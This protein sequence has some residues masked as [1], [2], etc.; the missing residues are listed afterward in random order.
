M[1]GLSAS[2]RRTGIDPD[3]ISATALSISAAPSPRPGE[4]PIPMTYQNNVHPT[5][6]VHD[7]TGHDAGDQYTESGMRVPAAEVRARAVA[8]QAGRWLSFA[9]ERTRMQPRTLTAKALQSTAFSVQRRASSFAIPSKLTGTSKHQRALWR[10]VSDPA[11]P[12]AALDLG[13]TSDGLTASHD[14]EPLGLVQTKHLGWVQPLV[15][16]G[17][18]LHLARVTGHD[19]EAYTLGANVAFGHVGQALDRL[20]VALSQA[21]ELGGS[22]G[23]DGAPSGPVAAAT[24]LP[25]PQ[26]STGDGAAHAV[27]QA[28]TPGP[29]AAAPLRLVV[30]PQHDAVRPGADPDDIVLFRRI[31][32][33]ACAS[34]DHVVRHSP[35]GIDWGRGS[36]AAARADLALSIVTHLAGPESVGHPGC[37]DLAEALARVPRAGGVIRASDVRAFIVESRP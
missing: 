14:G 9:T 18:T 12:W 11:E 13:A 32:G 27:V 10:L 24:S 22:S 3:G 26:V 16:F 30:R 15:P 25:E 28:P 8:E 33:A 20:L 7:R 36:G 19:Y 2:T 34:V 21:G 17:L 35:T 29:V 5:L 23:G 31:D 1:H 6:T 37:K 4:A